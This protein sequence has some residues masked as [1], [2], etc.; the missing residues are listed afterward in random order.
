MFLKNTGFYWKIQVCGLQNT[1]LYFQ[2]LA[3]L[4]LGAWHLYPILS[5]LRVKLLKCWISQKICTSWFLLPD[6]SFF[7]CALNLRMAK[8]L[9]ESSG[10]NINIHERPRYVCKEIEAA[11]ILMLSLENIGWYNMRKSICLWRTSNLPCR[12]VLLKIMFVCMLYQTIGT[13]W[14]DSLDRLLNWPT[15]H[16]GTFGFWLASKYMLKVRSYYAAIALCCC[17]A[18]S[19]AKIMMWLH[20]GVAWKLNSFQLEMRWSCGEL[21]QKVIN[22]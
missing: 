21:Q 16:L 15:N 9:K 8:L 1:G 4:Q 14:S 3:C 17:T 11:I 19:C 12:L 6:N 5:G 18:P 20:C 22:I 2:R 10:W 13:Q 7:F